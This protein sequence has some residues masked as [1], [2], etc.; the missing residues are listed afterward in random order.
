MCTVYLL[1][2][3]DSSEQTRSY[4]NSTMCLAKASVTSITVRPSTVTLLSSLYGTGRILTKWHLLGML[5]LHHNRLPYKLTMSVLSIWLCA[6]LCYLQCYTVQVIKQRA[7]ACLSFE[8]RIYL[9]CRK[10]DTFPL[11]LHYCTVIGCY[12]QQHFAILYL[13]LLPITAWGNTR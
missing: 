5:N 9:K 1:I 2:G 7:F 3:M 11:I 8:A 4:V 6:M 12:T 10:L 13:Y